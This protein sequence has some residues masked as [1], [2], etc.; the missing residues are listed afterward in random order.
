MK[1]A[2]IAVAVIA[3]AAAVAAGIFAGLYFTD[4]T[5]TKPPRLLVETDPLATSQR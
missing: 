3:A 2:L 5:K 1:I 4:D